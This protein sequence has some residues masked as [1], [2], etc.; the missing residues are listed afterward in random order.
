[1]GTKKLFYEDCHRQTFTAAVIS[2]EKTEKGFAVILD[3]TAFY[4]EGG[5]QACDVGTLEDV[6]VLDVQEAGEDILHFCDGP[7]IPGQQVTGRI[8]Y[9]RRL[10]LMQQHTGEH[11]LSGLIHRH[12]GFH[13]MGFHVGAAC[14]EVDFD[15]IIPQEALTQLELEANRAVWANLP[16]VCFVP[17][18]E[19][20]PGIEYRTKRKLPW[21]VRIVRIP[22]VDDCAC[23]GVH[24]AFTGEV[25]LIKILSCVKF[26]QGV[27]LELACGQ[28][29]LCYVNQAWEQNRLV[30]QQLSVK[31][32]QTAEAVKR[33]E[34]QLGEEKLRSAQLQRQLFDAVAEGYAKKGNVIHWQNGLS[35]GELRQLAEKI[36]A[37]C[38]GTA[39]VLS[40]AEEKTGVCIA[41][42]GGDVSAMGKALCD[43]F[44]GKGGG[45]EGFF[46]GTLVGEEKEIENYLATLFS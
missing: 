8:D 13:N 11:I 5:G 41:C 20:L 38:G 45:R 36:A 25:G 34:A 16:V 10:D 6:Q 19:E 22:G 44:A 7:L 30:A 12:F 31:Q 9:S 4:P 35:G 2:C 3:E 24:T 28:R 21:P 23:C 15:G 29:A 27:R 42:P 39:V 26:R 43:A 17:S 33:L 40:A 46:Q 14:M 37:R 1:M 18:E 32:H